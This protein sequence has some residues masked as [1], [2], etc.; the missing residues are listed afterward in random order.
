MIQ[1]VKR[2][3]QYLLLSLHAKGMA[4]DH[5]VVIGVHLHKTELH[6]RRRKSI[7]HLSNQRMHARIKHL[8][9]YI[10]CIEQL[11]ALDRVKAKPDKGFIQEA[12]PTA[13]LQLNT[14]LRT[15]AA[16]YLYGCFGNHRMSR[17]RI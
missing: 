5:F 15:A 10:R 2:D 17:N 1:F 9:A 12:L 7:I 3:A 14:F 11:E 8:A 6:V 4:G 16:Q 13:N